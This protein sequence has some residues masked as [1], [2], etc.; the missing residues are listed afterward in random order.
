MK[1]F[2]YVISINSVNSF[3][4]LLLTLMFFSFSTVV[5]A[6]EFSIDRSANFNSNKEVLKSIIMDYANYGQLRHHR[7]Y[8]SGIDEI[9]IVKQIDENHFYTWTYVNDTKDYKYFNYVEVSEDASGVIRIKSRLATSN[10]VS[11]L[12]AETGLPNKSFFDSS[13]VVWI[14]KENLDSRGN[15]IST[16]VRYVGAFSASSFGISL[17]API[18]RK[19]LDKT[20]DQMFTVLK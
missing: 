1:N 4:V 17:I 6:K 20:A 11:S 19:N 8:L 3:I 18:I 14:I 16:T 7:Y 2:N 13:D 9:K 15:L 5:S 10:E 12:T